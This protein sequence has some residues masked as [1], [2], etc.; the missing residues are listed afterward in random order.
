MKNQIKKTLKK[1]ARFPITA[2]KGIFET[3]RLVT[4]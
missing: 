1:W 4:P 2:F 3:E